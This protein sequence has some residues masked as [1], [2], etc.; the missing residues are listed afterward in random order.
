[1]NTRDARTPSARRRY[2]ERGRRY[3]VDFDLRTGSDELFRG[4]RGVNAPLDPESEQYGEGES[5]T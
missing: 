4:R 5:K 3:G 2:C 1:M